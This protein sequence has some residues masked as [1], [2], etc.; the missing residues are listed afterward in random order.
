M[1]ADPVLVSEQ[2]I[3]PLQ[4]PRP[5]KEDRATSTGMQTGA[6]RMPADCSVSSPGTETQKKET[7]HKL[8][9]RKGTWAKCNELSGSHRY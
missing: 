4:D 1:I 2:S 3:F 8:K 7:A 6:R 9:Q 5:S